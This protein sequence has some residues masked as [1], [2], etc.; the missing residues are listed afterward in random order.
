MAEAALSQDEL[1]K[2]V[3]Y[4]AVDDYVKSGM[5]VGLGTGSTA[6]FAVERVGEKLKSGE[7]KDIV[8]I[9]TSVRTK[10]QAESL[11]IPLVTLDTHSK[12]DVAIDGADEVDPDLNLVKGGGGALLREKMVEICADK[13]IV[14]VDESKL[15]DGL[16]PGFPVP[17]EITPFCHEHIMRTIAALPS[18]E[19]CKPVLRMGSSQ[20]N[21]IDGDEIAIT[22][23]GNYIVDLHFKEAIKDAPKMAEE[24]KNVCGV[25]DHGLFCGMT[26]AVIIAGSDGISVKE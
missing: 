12:L 17:V 4:K 2:Q 21:Q 19:G 6:Y 13:F 1:K 7:L 24:L 20:N 9:P 22:D 25:V 14:I 8:A 15:C 26:T 11:D 5:V 18:C 23:N 16:G 10:E 3:G